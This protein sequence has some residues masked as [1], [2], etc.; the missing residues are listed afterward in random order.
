[1]QHAPGTARL[2]QIDLKHQ[3][4][5][6]CISRMYISL[7]SE[8]SLSRIGRRQGVHDAK[9]SIKLSVVLAVTLRDPFPVLVQGDRDRL[10]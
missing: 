4:I 8:A 3:G 7:L 2:L 10:L 6:T 5:S 1:M 9:C